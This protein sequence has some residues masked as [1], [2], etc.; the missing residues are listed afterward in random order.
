MDNEKLYLVHCII[1]Q[2]QVIQTGS[3]CS[4]MNYKRGLRSLLIS[5]AYTVCLSSFA[6]MFDDSIRM[7][8]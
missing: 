8:G 2:S 3:V 6:T 1:V 7:L 5:G 4:L